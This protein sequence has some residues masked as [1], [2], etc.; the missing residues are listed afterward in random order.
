VAERGDVDGALSFLRQGKAIADELG[1]ADQMNR[2]YGNLGHVLMQASRLQEAVDLIFEGLPDDEE[3]NWLRLHAAG[4]NG[5]EAL[6]RLGRLQDADDLL[7]QLV[8]RGVGSC[9]FGPNGVRALMAIRGG[10][11]ED[12]VRFLAAAE[13]L[14]AGL[15]TVQV[16]GSLHML[17]AE[18]YL[19]RGEPRAALDEIERALTLAAG[20]DDATYTAEM[21]SFGLRALADDF[22]ESRSRGRRLDFDKVE[23]HAVGLVEELDAIVENRKLRGYPS[24]PRLRA[25][26][27]QCHAEASRLRA[28]DAEKWREAVALWESAQEPYPTA[29]CRWREAEALLSHRDQRRRAADCV[30]EAWRTTVKLGAPTL[31]ARLERLA[32]RARIALDPAEAAEVPATAA[33]AADLALTTREVEV[34]AQLAKGRTDRQIAEELFISRKTASVHV[35]NLLRK[36]DVANRIEAAEIGQRAGLS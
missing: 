4:Q 34:L 32:A 27:A 33:I 1:N 24:K 6:I 22:E 31:Q 23:R 13:E 2:A 30:K 3:P 20:T 18:L 8:D 15:S 14:S 19:E 10:R 9:V 17:R 29:Y 7:C 11:F 26:T 12:A 25:F 36:L 16:G 5:A 28:P 35:S 21:Y